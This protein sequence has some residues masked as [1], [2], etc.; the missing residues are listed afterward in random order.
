MI[1]VSP[2]NHTKLTHDGKLFEHIL[3]KKYSLQVVR[4][5]ERMYLF[6]RSHVNNL[7]VIKNTVL[8]TCRFNTIFTFSQYPKHQL[9]HAS[10]V[11]TPNNASKP[12]L[13]F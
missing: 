8:L 12:K 11:G 4:V 1:N 7:F 6:R 2:Y 10:T 9:P 13:N 5:V 3:L